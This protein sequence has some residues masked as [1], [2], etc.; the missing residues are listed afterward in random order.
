MNLRAILTLTMLAASAG[1]APTTAVV[2][3]T[4]PP[5]AT[6]ADPLAWTDATT[7]TASAEGRHVRIVTPATGATA[8]TPRTLRVRVARVFA[9]NITEIANNVWALLGIELEGAFP[10]K[11]L[12]MLAAPKQGDGPD[13]WIQAERVATIRHVERGAGPL[14]LTLTMRAAEPGEHEVAAGM[15]DGLGGLARRLD[16]RKPEALAALRSGYVMKL[17]AI[18][19]QNV[20]R[21]RFPIADAGALSAGGIAIVML[22]PA[23]SALAS[24][25]DESA[26]PDQLEVRGRRLVWRANGADY[27]E[28][29][30][31][32]V[33]IEA[34]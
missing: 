31:V 32:I 6:R 22:P 10:G 5:A 26:M 23:G 17:G 14:L 4:P 2:A 1:C 9:R 34:E 28:S 24:K 21:H 27:R 19:A 15:V 33:Q 20:W 25:L 13:R 12:K 3:R 30:F 7:R 18:G 8:A 11:T 29:P 16:A